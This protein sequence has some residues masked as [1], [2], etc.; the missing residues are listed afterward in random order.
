MDR[1]YLF[2]LKL[3]LKKNQSSLFEE[4]RG[5]LLK[6][7]IM[8]HPGAYVRKGIEWIMANTNTIDQNAIFFKF[9][10]ITTKTRDKFD[11]NSR[12]FIE[13]EDDMVDSTRCIFDS[14]KQILAIERR[15]NT[16]Y[17]SILARYIADIINNIHET[18]LID[19]LK[20][21]KKAF[22]SMCICETHAISDPINFIEY[23]ST[24]FK[25]TEFDVTFFRKNPPDFEELLQKPMQSFLEETG[26][27]TSSAG[28]KSKDGL[29]I[30]KLVDVSRA[31]A[32]SGSDA[33]ARIQKTS[34]SRNER[35][36]L[37]TKKN[38]AHID[39]DK[40]DYSEIDWLTSLANTIRAKYKSIRGRNNG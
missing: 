1:F 31:A 40:Y 22:L 27:D 29:H 11:K 10:R 7:I 25:V 30:E 8:L 36:R 37:K 32:A 35:V 18:P 16:P 9:G 2:R 26:G 34:D 14:D 13:A 28:V 5:L 33:S 3:V 17:P 39:V 12:Q 19:K 20:N 21:S 24:A 23:I 4:D 38:I 15:Y 6:E